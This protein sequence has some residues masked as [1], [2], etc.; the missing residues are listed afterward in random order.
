MRAADEGAT[1]TAED[2]AGGIDA[3]GPACEVAGFSDDPQSNVT[4]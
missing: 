3:E 2:L 1:G 4:P